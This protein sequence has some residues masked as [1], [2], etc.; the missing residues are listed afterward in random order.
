MLAAVCSLVLSAC[1]G[2]AATPANVIARG[3][4][5]CSTAASAVR[6]APSPAG[7]STAALAHYLTRVAPVIDTEVAA[8]RA[9]PRPARGR[10][11]LDAFIAAEAKLAADY[12]QLAAAARRGDQGAV[13]RA[14]GA[15]QSS[16]APALATRYGLSQ[17]T[18]STGTVR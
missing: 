3:N 6:A 12:R 18:G 4:A 7:S 10:S 17:C 14:L 5:I 8:L 13:S 15:L 11:R 2:H 16:D 1:G 9:L